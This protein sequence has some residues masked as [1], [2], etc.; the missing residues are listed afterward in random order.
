MA[1]SRALKMRAPRRGPETS[2]VGAP[3]RGPE[4]EPRDGAPRRSPQT[5]PRDGAPRRS[6]ETPRQSQWRPPRTY[7]KYLPRPQD[8]HKV[9]P[10]H[11]GLKDVPKVPPH[12]QGRTSSHLLT[13]QDVPKVPPHTPGRTAG[14]SRHLMTYLKYTSRHPRT[15]ICIKMG[16]RVRSLEQAVVGRTGYAE[17][18][19][20]SQYQTV[21]TSHRRQIHVH[22]AIDQPPEGLQLIHAAPPL[23]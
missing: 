13:P 14:T 4:T 20:R 9:P 18:T 8:V 10:D 16:V 22:A 2:R 6:P 17:P 1:A 21:K 5:E 23:L 11:P 3:R 12:T 19:C 7:L 15:Y